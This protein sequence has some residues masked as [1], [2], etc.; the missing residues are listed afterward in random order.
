M[1][2]EMT[3]PA[4]QPEESPTL[5]Q[6]QDRL[7]YQ[8]SDSSLLRQSLVHRSYLN[9]VQEPG[10]RSNE[11]LEFLG[12]A[13]L[14][15][16]VALR[17]YEEYPD[18]EEGWLTIARSQLVRNNTLG[19][20]ARELNLGECLLL[21]A[22]VAND[23]ARERFS[24]LSR[25]FEA[26]VGAVYLDGGEQAARQVIWRLLDEQFAA[27]RS[28][29]LQV[30]AKSTLQQFAQSRDGVKPTYEIIAE[31]GPPHD[32]SFRAV[33]QIHGELVAEGVGRSKQAAEMDAA[34]HALESLEASTETEAIN[35]RSERAN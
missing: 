27:L 34:R 17:L 5:R 4:I 9:E 22:G 21:G 28:Q 6:L 23:G 1:P 18:A 26:V 8:F 2:Q 29:D 12:D 15:A 20:L 19:A 11:R 3:T 30:D 35:A 25:A 7:Q 31:S 14:G 10:L 32:R 13:V 24:V 33:V 16:V